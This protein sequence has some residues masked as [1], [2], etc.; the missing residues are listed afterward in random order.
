M[1]FTVI[2][3]NGRVPRDAKSKAFLYTDNWDDW[4]KYRTMFSLHVADEDGEVH[5][6]GSVK[7]GQKGLKPSGQVSENHRAPSLS[8]HFDKLDDKYFSLGQ[9]EDYYESLHKLSDGLRS[10]VFEGL[11]DCAANLDIFHA[12]RDEEVMNESLLRDVRESSVTGRLNRLARGDARL[13]KFAFTY[14]LGRAGRTPPAEM[15]FEVTPEA[16]PPTN[17]HVLIGR[18]GVGKTRCMRQLALTLLGRES[19]DNRSLGTI[20]ML[21]ED[22]G[23]D[24]AFAGLVLVSFSAFD[25]FELVPDE[26][27]TMTCQQVGLRK[28][29]S[30]SGRSMAKSFDDLGVDFANSLTRCQSSVRAERWRTAVKT[31]EEDDLFAEA[32]VT[33]LLD[34]EDDTNLNFRARR[35]FKKLSSGHAIVLLTVTRLVE[36][37]DERTLVLLDEPEGHLHPPLLSSF[38]RCLSDLLVRR[39]GVAIVATHSPVVLQEVPRSCAWKLRRSGRTSVVERPTV[40]TFGE[41]IGV[42]TREVFGLQ[43]TQSGF[44]RLLRDAVSDGSSY[45]RVLTKFEGQLGDEAKAIVQGLIAERDEDIDA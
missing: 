25:E 10:R 8:R 5:R 38:V 6:I 14:R 15:S 11:R 30:A 12:F 40:E 39:N 24:M 31:L 7:I 35:L 45:R 3:G 29:A 4:G 27:D 33:S 22:T 2:D 34:E 13:T 1:F 17:V 41:N 18:N 42:L 43:V 36:L 20:E 9:D 26:A 28:H 19:D 21:A 32:D 44:H 37:V 23:D 16:Q